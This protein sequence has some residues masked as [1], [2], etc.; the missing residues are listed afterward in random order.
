MFVMLNSR[1]DPEIDYDSKNFG[2]QK[3]S[4][5]YGDAATFR[6]KFYD[7][8]K[9]VSS[10]NNTPEDYKELLPLFVFDV[11]KQSEKLKN[12]VDRYTNYSTVLRKCTS[13]H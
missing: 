13:Q 3:F 11:S 5:V 8:E 6:T 12:G 9:L 1:R 4:R 10:P 7:V 2:P